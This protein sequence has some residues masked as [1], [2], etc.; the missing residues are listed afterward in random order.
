MR[1]TST[2]SKP[3]Q[4]T[5]TRTTRKHLVLVARSVLLTAR[6]TTNLS[7]RPGSSQPTLLKPPAKP[8]TLIERLL[9]PFNCLK[10]R[11]RAYPLIPRRPLHSTTDPFGQQILLL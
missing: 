10:K 8:P 6:T 3:L 1:S 4:P 5:T 9:A 2:Y 11:G 7:Q